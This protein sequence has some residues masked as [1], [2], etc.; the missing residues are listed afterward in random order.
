MTPQA[1]QFW[2]RRLAIPAYRV[3]EAA[4]YAHVSPQTVAAWHKK[5]TKAPVLSERKEREGL[6]FLQLI[7]LAVVADMRK[8]GVKL[9]EIDRARKYFKETTGLEYPFAQLRFKTDGA[10]VFSEIEGPLGSIVEDKLLAGNHQGQYT[11]KEM[12]QAKLHEFN[13]DDQGSVV[14]WNVAGVNK[15]IVIDPQ[16]AF[17][18]PQIHG[19]KTALI[20]SRWES[21]EE[22]D[23]IAEDFGLAPQHVIEALLFEGLEPGDPRLARWMN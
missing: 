10:D 20:K 12:L 7:E 6:S 11:W 17:G 1:H 8:L 13:Y 4:A 16:L 18:A 2:K 14:A 3:G 15:D 22:A 9:T 23:E 21:G 5:K 19:V